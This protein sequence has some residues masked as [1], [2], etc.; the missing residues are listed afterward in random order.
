MDQGIRNEPRFLRKFGEKVVDELAVAFVEVLTVQNGIETDARFP[1]LARQV[2]SS[3]RI[4]MYGRNSIFEDSPI[5]AG[6]K[7][8]AVT[9]LGKG[10]VFAKVL[11]LMLLV[12]S[13]KKAFG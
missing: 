7:L 1:I 9:T 11:R 6:V 5:S 3:L 8:N 13:S 10:S 2:C 12:R 4:L